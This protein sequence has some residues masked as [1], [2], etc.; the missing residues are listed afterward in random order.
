MQ[1]RYPSLSE[2]SHSGNSCADTGGFVNFDH[3]F[4]VY[5]GWP[6][7]AGLHQSNNE[8]PFKW[9]LAGVS[10]MAQH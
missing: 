2:Y 9:Y 4:L 10:M 5:E 3:V 6:L 7:Q 8:T 1:G